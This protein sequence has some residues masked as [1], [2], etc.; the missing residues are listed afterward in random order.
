MLD[1]NE[2]VTVANRC[3]KKLN[4]TWDG[5]PYV[6]PPYPQ[7]ITLPR[8][9]AVAARFQN[10]VMGRGT[11]MEDWASKSEYLIGIVEDRDPVTPIEQT[12]SPQR[13]DSE[14]VNGPDTEVIRPRGGVSEVRQ[15][16]KSTGDVGFTR[17]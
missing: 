6:I 8:I 11:P 10:P 15:T 1:A 12:N 3:S 9:V 5:K 2:F 14:L 13:W 16:P 7:Q 4:A 17:D